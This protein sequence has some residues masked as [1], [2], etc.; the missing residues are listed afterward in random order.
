M[1]G[2]FKKKKKGKD[3]DESDK[4]AAPENIKDSDKDLERLKSREQILERDRTAVLENKNGI[5]YSNKISSA[6]KIQNPFTGE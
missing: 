5:S 2:L 6:L 3:S 1:L 4:V